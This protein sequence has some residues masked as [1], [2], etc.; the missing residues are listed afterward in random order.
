RLHGEVVREFARREWSEDHGRVN[1]PRDH[2]LTCERV[3]SRWISSAGD[4]PGSIR[5]LVEATRADA[6]PAIESALF[7]VEMGRV[8][9][10]SSLELHEAA[11]MW[12]LLGRLLGTHAKTAT[13]A[14]DYAASIFR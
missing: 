10:E 3:V 13:A 4:A 12:T 14:L 7:V 11:A 5:A 2:E 1:V 8:A 9:A 6:R